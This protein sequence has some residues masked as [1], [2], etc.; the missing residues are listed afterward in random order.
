MFGGRRGLVQYMKLTEEEEQEQVE[1]ERM[2]GRHNQA[3]WQR[4]TR[5]QMKKTRS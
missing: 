2:K 4:V 3:V 5:K 1:V